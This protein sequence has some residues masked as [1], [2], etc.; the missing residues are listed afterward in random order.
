M[1]VPKILANFIPFV[2]CFITFDMCGCIQ[3]NPGP[4]KNNTCY[5][6]SLR[7]WHLN[8]VAT[9]NFSKLS[10]LEPYNIQHKFDM[11]CL[12]E[13]FL[14]SSIPHYDERLYLKGNK[15]VRADN[16]SDNKKGGV[17]I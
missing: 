3:L 1:P 14:D 16:S 13:T 5:I 6:F 7:H 15:L 8:S 17:G 12:L 4:R 11:I 9:Q 2:A 10:L